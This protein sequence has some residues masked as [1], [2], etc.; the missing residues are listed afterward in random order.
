MSGRVEASAEGAWAVRRR[1][2][3]AALLGATL[4]MLGAW[5]PWL[6]LYAG[7]Q[8]YGGFTG[9]YGWVLL[10]GGALA[11]ASSVGAMRTRHRWLEW[12]TTVL[13]LALIAFTC[14]L[15]VG[16]AGMLRRGASAMLVARA[17]PG[18]FVALLGA[19]LVT[20]SPVIGLVRRR[21]R[22]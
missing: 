2:A 18:L 22:P 6:T 12:G 15:L 13:G 9:L 4:V 20:M 11:L 16:L 17:G 21:R 3:V 8:R 10:A 7:L 19:A 1:W 14:W 5:L